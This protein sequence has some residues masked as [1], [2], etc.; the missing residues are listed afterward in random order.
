MDPF[1][2]AFNSTAILKNTMSVSCMPHFMVCSVLHCV[3]CCKGLIPSHLSKRALQEAWRLLALLS[4]EVHTL[5][6]AGSITWL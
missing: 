5:R 2:A 3:Q 1:L 6:L 4:L